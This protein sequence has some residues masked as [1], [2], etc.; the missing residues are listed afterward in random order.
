MSVFPQVGLTPYA[1]SSGLTL[2]FGD[3]TKQTLQIF[4]PQMS[5]F[6][7][8]GLTPYAPSSGLTLWLCPHIGATGT[9]FV[10][11]LREGDSE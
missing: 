9:V 8:V 7:Q 1:P 5:V 11:E 10:K 4:N 3:L 6:P 2:W